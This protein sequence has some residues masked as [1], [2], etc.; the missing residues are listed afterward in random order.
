MENVEKSER[1]KAVSMRKKY[2]TEK[3]PR[4]VSAFK[5]LQGRVRDGVTT[6]T[7][8][9]T[10]RGFN[11]FLKYV[12]PCPND[13]KCPTIGRKDHEKGYQPGNCS[14]QEKS[15]N[16]REACERYLSSN[17]SFDHL[18]KANLNR[19]KK[20]GARKRQSIKLKKIKKELFSSGYEFNKDA[21]MN[22]SISGTKRHREMSQEEKTKRAKAI[23]KSSKKRIAKMSR[24]EIAAMMAHMRSFK[25]ENKGPSR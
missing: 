25:S 15:D 2:P 8:S 6:T 9:R 24:S 19:W 18:I 3:W 1:D 4:E 7:W 13:M 16:S 14:W 17:P 5:G 20:P 23:S 21:R 10:T 22:M 12:G 11:A